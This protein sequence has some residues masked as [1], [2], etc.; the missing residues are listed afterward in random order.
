MTTRDKKRISGLVQQVHKA[1]HTG[2]EGYNGDVPL[3]I[4]MCLPTAN[5]GT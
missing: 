5:L 3:V 2:T 1:K 4:P